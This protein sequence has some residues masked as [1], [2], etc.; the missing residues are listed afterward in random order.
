EE[1]TERQE[2]A[3]GMMRAN[4]RDAI[5][6]A[7]GTSLQYF[8]GIQW[9]AGERLFA[10]VL[11][12]KGQAFFV[13]PAFEQGRAEEQI[14]K[15]PQ[16]DRAEIRIWQEDESPYK[17]LAEGLRDLGIATGTL[18]VEETA[19]FVFS[20]GVAHAAPQIRITS[21]TPVTAGCRMIKSAQ[22]IALMRLA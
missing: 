16:K 4:G 1:R 17:K 8:T 22:E 12:A 6:L 5:L 3:R 14:A 10:M 13:C 7:P 2:K 15:S 9:W 11:P 21:A 20:D 18:G 19:K